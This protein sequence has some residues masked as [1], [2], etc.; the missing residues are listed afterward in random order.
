MSCLVI[1][2]VL[3]TIEM[4]RV[5]REDPS[6][7]NKHTVTHRRNVFYLF[8]SSSPSQNS[9][10]TKERPSGSR[11]AVTLVRDEQKNN[12]HDTQTQIQQ[13]DGKQE[14]LVEQTV[15]ITKTR[16]IFSKRGQLTC[17]IENVE[18]Y[19]TEA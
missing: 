11:T 18:P 4:S 6:E 19:R 16:T 7:Y 12:E 2:Q 17:H 13:A 9:Y 3:M 5:K 10:T 1:I 8:H 14:N 15:R